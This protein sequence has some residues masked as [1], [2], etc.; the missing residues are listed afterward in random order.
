MASQFRFDTVRAEMWSMIRKFTAKTILAS[1]AMLLPIDGAFSEAI[2]SK[3]DIYSRSIPFQSADRLDEYSVS[4]LWFP[5][6]QVPFAGL[7]GPA[8]FVFKNVKSGEQWTIAV[9]SIVLLDKDFWDKHQVPDAGQLEP[10]VLLEKLAG[11]GV[12]SISL[13]KDKR[14]KVVSCE[15]LGFV[16]LPGKAEEER[17][18]Q[19]GDAVVDLQDIDFDGKKELV[20]RHAGIGQRGGDAYEIARNPKDIGPL[21]RDSREPFRDIDWRTVINITRKQIIIEGSNGACYDTA[22]TYSRDGIG[23]MSMTHFWRSVRREPD[24]CDVE[25]YSAVNQLKGIGPRLKLLSRRKAD[26]P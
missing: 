22:A 4:G 18:L 7:S 19:L 14:A 23:V 25:D 3:S 8:I 13:S 24:G 9:N 2:T 15:G 26:G 21:E 10:K 5:E 20:F 6:E 1:A 11:F 17:C 16:P 12:A